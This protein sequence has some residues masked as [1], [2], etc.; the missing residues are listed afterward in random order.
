MTGHP[1]HIG[2][3]TSKVGR[4]LFTAACLCGWTTAPARSLPALWRNIRAQHP[5]AIPPTCP[6][7]TKHA[8]GSRYDAEIAMLAFW[9]TARGT[10]VPRRTYECAC[11]NWHTTSQATRG[12]R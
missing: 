7:P 1:I 4:T 11:G 6:T 5:Q 8:Y 12:V 3:T 2:Q 10:R 9:K